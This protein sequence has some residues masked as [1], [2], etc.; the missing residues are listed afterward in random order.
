MKKCILILFLFALAKISFSQTELNYGSVDSITYQQYL[1]KD[2][3]NLIKTVKKAEFNHI[4]FYYLEYRKAIA[5]YELKQY[6]KASES[7][8][9]V[10]LE[11]PDDNFAKESLYLSYLYGGMYSEL[12][13]FWHTLEGDLHEKLRLYDDELIINGIDLEYKA[14]LPD[15]YQVDVENGDTLTQNIK[16]NLNYFSLNLTHLTKKNFTLFH[17]ISLL[18]GENIVYDAI[19]TLEPIQQFV[20]QWQYYAI[21]SFNLKN[22]TNL[23]LAFNYTNEK[24]KGIS[25]NTNSG[26]G[27]GSSNQENVH[28]LVYYNS[29]VGYIAL[30]KQFSALNLQISTSLSNLSLQF[31]WQTGVSLTYFPFY[32]NKFS[33]QNELYFHYFTKIDDSNKKLLF[34][35]TFDFNLGKRI[36]L[37]PFAFYGNTYDFIDNQ[38]FTTYSGIDEINYWYGTL[39]NLRLGKKTFFY[40][41]YQN[42]LYTNS[43]KINRFEKEIQYKTQTLLGGISWNY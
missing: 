40:L 30:E 29:F 14:F 5:Y 27:W 24:F 11:Y 2:W 41:L 18:K 19:F 42:Y 4:T 7:F 33:W 38:G 37:K 23:R 13:R 1:A 9:K 15:K 6:R 22:Q 39:L 17:S 43:Y 36:N 34:K 32:N 3:D 31:Q 10:L 12:R 21:G 20:T 8:Q 28:Y 25:E 35:T 26:S 16:K